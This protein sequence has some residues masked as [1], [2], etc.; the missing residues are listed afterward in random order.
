MNDQHWWQLSRRVLCPFRLARALDAIP[1]ANVLLAKRYKAILRIKELFKIVLVT[2]ILP[3]K[4]ITCKVH[5]TAAGTGSVKTRKSSIL[6]LLRVH[7]VFSHVAVCFRVP[8]N[9]SVMIDTSGVLSSCEMLPSESRSCRVMGCSLIFEKRKR[10]EF[11]SSFS[12]N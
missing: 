8:S 1:L 3:I 2:L 12:Q 5:S 11:F 9:S 6:V 4:E 7:S 10:N